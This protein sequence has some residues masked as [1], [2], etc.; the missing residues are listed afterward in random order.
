MNGHCGAATLSWSAVSSPPQ[1]ETAIAA[2][3]MQA[4]R[5]GPTRRMLRRLSRR[6]NERSRSA[7][8]G[9][10]HLDELLRHPAIVSRERNDG[11]GTPAGI[12]CFERL[13][14][15]RRCAP[16]HRAR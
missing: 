8:E 14:A 16:A 5:R 15:A 4:T 10:V 1:A 2:A 13:G 9:D 12:P 3:L 11:N 7:Q 6:L